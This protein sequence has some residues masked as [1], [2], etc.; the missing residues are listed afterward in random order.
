MAVTSTSSWRP[1]TA[2]AAWLSFWACGNALVE[3]E[4]ANYQVMLTAAMAMMFSNRCTS[5]EMSVLRRSVDRRISQFCR[6]V[7]HP[8]SGW[9]RSQCELT[10]HLLDS[11]IVIHVFPANFRF[12]ERMLGTVSLASLR[13]FNRRKISRLIAW[14]LLAS[15]VDKLVHVVIRV[16]ENGQ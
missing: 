4:Y 8:R 2:V 10:V 12:V 13:S 15:H 9:T 6:G 1:S 11:G 5:T 3:E 16:G 14:S 7:G